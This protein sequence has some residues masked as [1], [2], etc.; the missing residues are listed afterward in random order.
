MNS[1]RLATVHGHLGT[2]R[3]RAQETG[4][5]RAQETMLAETSYGPLLGQ[6][7]SSGGG[8]SAAGS[9]S[10]LGVPYCEQPVPPRRFRPVAP[11]RKRWVAPR[12]CF[13]HGP[14]APQPLA[15]QLADTVKAPSLGPELL[16]A[17]SL[18]AGQAEACCFLNVYRPAAAQ[19]DGRPR[20]CLVWFHGGGMTFGSARKNEGSFL[21]M[22]ADA[23]VIT[24]NYRIGMLGFFVPAGGTANLGILDQCA[25][26]RW[27]QQEASC[28]SGDA[29]NVTIFGLSSG[30][31]CT[32]ALL[33]CPAAEGLFAK[34]IVLS[35]S[36]RIGHLQT[37]MP[38]LRRKL[39]HFLK[40]S[41]EEL[42][43][44]GL[45]GYSAAELLEAQIQLNLRGTLL[46]DGGGDCGQRSNP[47][48]SS[49]SAPLTQPCFAGGCFDSTRASS[50]A[51]GGGRAGM[52][53]GPLIIGCAGAEA[54]H[55]G[56]EPVDC[57]T[58]QMAPKGEV[59]PPRS[60]LEVETG[61]AMLLGLQLPAGL[62]VV[63][64]LVQAY[65][66]AA[67]RHHSGHG[68][69][70]AAVAPETVWCELTRDLTYGMLATRFADAHAA[71]GM[72]ATGGTCKTWLYR[73][74]RHVIEAEQP[75]HSLETS[76]TFGRFAACKNSHVALTACVGGQ[77]VPLSPE[78]ISEEAVA[79]EDDYI[80]YW[81]AFA[82]SGDPN[83]RPDGGEPRRRVVWRP[84]RVKGDDEAEA[85]L[86]FGT[87]E[88]RVAMGSDAMPGARVMWG[89]LEREGLLGAY[90]EAKGKIL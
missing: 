76:F 49:S 6:V 57:S 47:N 53:S 90:E 15:P 36:P 39:A 56:L 43:V 17:G 62:A 65:T 24:V 27:V 45:Q 86:V 44:E 60:V 35:A 32:A 52:F 33:G 29:A 31:T 42:T 22:R 72:A 2:G 41:T 4:R 14:L 54:A 55:F 40:C 73:S 21:A 89:F 83:G 12:P 18:P 66:A 58:G 5:P 75:H 85:T 81:A 59:S 50:S 23:V 88:C 8:V 19:A 10:F 46:V 51:G 34:A 64:P 25:A 37:T 30:G 63:R 61:M 9:V 80:G 82:W 87:P 68:D 28:F 38:P 7:H 16:A 20:P 70:S 69:S 84:R 13:E 3:P 77:T 11:L 79:L 67:A 48:D 1:P 71:A 78:D 74:D 26:L